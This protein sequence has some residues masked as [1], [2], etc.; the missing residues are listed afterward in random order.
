MA[1]KMLINA[2]Q[3]EELRVALVDG[4]ILD[5]IDF[6]RLGRGQQKG[7][8][9]K[10]RIT[11]V[12]PSLEAAFVDYGADRHGFL[13]LKEV[14]P[15]YYQS[16]FREDRGSSRNMLRSGQEVIVQIDKEERGTKGAA[17]TTYIGLAGC[18]S[19]LMPN[20]PKG[21][22]ISR[23]IEGEEREE[24]RDI[25]SQLELPETMGII[26]RTAGLGR[27]I[28]ELQWDLSVLLSQWTAIQEASLHGAAPFL[29]YQESD[30]ILRAIRDYLRPDVEEILVDTPE[31]FE[32][33]RNHVRVV[34]PD[35][36]GRVKFYDDSTSLFNRYQV[37]SQIESAHQKV[38]QL[39]NR[40]SIVI[41]HT[42]ALVAID[43]NSARATEG[44]DI[45]ETALNTNLVAAKE[46]AR[47]MRL[48]D[49]GGLVVI[50][51]IDMQ[52]T[53]NQRTVENLLRDELKHDRARVQMGRISRFGLLE[54]SRQRLRPSLGDSSH[55]TCPRCTGKGTIRSVTSLALAILRVIEEETLKPNTQQIRVHLPVDVA[56][57]LINEKRDALSKLE[58]R[59]HTHILL[60]PNMNFTSPHYELERIRKDEYNQMSSVESHLLA[61]K[62][63][64]TAPVMPGASPSSSQPEA[65]PAM[66]AF[67]QSPAPMRAEKDASS[68]IRRIWSAVFGSAEEQETSKTTP[69]TSASP[70]RAAR[71]ARRDFRDRREG[72]S[73]AGRTHHPRGGRD[74]DNRDNR[75]NRDQDR[76]KDNARNEDEEIIDN[77]QPDHRQS[78]TRPAH[79]RGNRTGSYRQGG[80]RSDR[81]DRSER[82]ER[83]ERTDRPVENRE[84]REP[85]EPRENRDTRDNNRDTRTR[86]P[87]H[88]R[89]RDTREVAPRDV[90]ESNDVRETRDIQENQGN[91]DH[92]RDH[93]RDNQGNRDQHR[94]RERNTQHRR[95]QHAHE[96]N[97]D[98]GGHVPHREHREINDVREVREVRENRPPVER[99]QPPVQAAAPKAPVVQMPVVQKSVVTPVVEQKKPEVIVQPPK[100]IAPPRAVKGFARPSKD[101]ASATMV[102]FDEKAFTSAIENSV[103][104]G[105]KV[106]TT[107]PAANVYAYEPV[108]KPQIAKIKP[109]V[110]ATE[111]ATDAAPAKSAQDQE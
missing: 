73:N 74:R 26:I 23:R 55:V 57:Y 110:Q 2:T 36:E 11:R 93:N 48:R 111:P 47:Q 65:E 6:E 40:A 14:A 19:V 16:D 10:G 108:G 18:Y 46:I 71:P 81:S 98:Q 44:S 30:V 28:D 56:T 70:T 109:K 22:G 58:K 89:D 99:V 72:S 53:R 95:P 102:Q 42:E 66:K 60:L 4:Q 59:H 78:D 34:R 106:V 104:V 62:E 29:I 5:G 92:N 37:E 8:I 68:L 85:R 90:R 67:L 97:D 32:K 33:V 87:S 50:D 94:G 45:E 35:F 100:T 54:L 38:V 101:Q 25:L 63:A 1:K 43:I 76:N 64:P 17:L 39:P 52:S 83:F 9:Y 31:A 27:S 103:S 20:N 24:M 107:K 82:P 86:Q 7:N 12:E 69:S 13:P 75:D 91:R 84:V 51:F 49:L 21:G 88:H 80:Q 105:T 3:K 79:H 77:R 41:D 61:K 96:A 15:E